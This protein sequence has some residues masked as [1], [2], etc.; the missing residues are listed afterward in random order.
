LKNLARP[1]AL[2]AFAIVFPVAVAAAVQGT[3]VTAKSGA[4]A[5]VIWDATPAVAGIV[6]DK[7]PRDAAMKSLE[8]Q[9]MQIAGQRAPS[10][11]DA[12]TITV[13]VVYQKTGAVNPAYGTPTFAGVERVFDL[14]VDAAAAKSQSAALSQAL[15]AGNTPK[16]VTVQVSGELP[17]M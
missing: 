11:S 10:L 1:L 14:T 13:R 4:H 16:G 6:S 7:Q 15:A 3:V 9:A 8:S 17:P 5:M 2:A 12:Q